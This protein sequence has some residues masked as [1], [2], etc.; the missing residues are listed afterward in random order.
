MLYRDDID[1]TLTINGDKY[2]GVFEADEGVIWYSV[3]DSN[4]NEYQT[5]ETPHPRPMFTIMRFT[6]EESE[7]FALGYLDAIKRARQ[8]FK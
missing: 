6:K 2:T 5:R 8:A 3:I 4:G 1:G 7:T